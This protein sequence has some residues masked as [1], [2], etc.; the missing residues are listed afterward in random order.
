MANQIYKDYLEKILPSIKTPV[1]FELGV[2]IGQDTELLYNLCKDPIYHGFEPDP[3]NIEAFKSKDIADKITFVEAAISNKNGTSIFYQSSGH[4]PNHNRENTASSS[5]YKPKHHLNRW[6]WTKFKTKIDVKT[7]TLDSY[8]NKNNIDHIDFIWSDIQG[9]EYYMILGGQEILKNT[10][11]IFMEYENAEL[12]EG[13]KQLNQVMEALPGN[14]A[15][16][17]NYYSDIFVV[18]NSYR[19]NV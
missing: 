16:K 2:H 15:L 17:K 14:W 4:P 8:C 13:H 11:Y 1:I 12:Y 9:G 5:L 19:Y 18:N 7:I 6:P 10:H 3:R